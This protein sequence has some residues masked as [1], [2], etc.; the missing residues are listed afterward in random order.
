[1]EVRSSSSWSREPSAPCFKR[2][3]TPPGHMGHTWAALHRGICTQPG[4]SWMVY[5]LFSATYNI[6][7]QY[8]VI[9]WAFVSSLQHLLYKLGCCIQVEML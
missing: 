3:A 4:L 2:S 7:I 1:M 5:L 9:M 8:F 6:L